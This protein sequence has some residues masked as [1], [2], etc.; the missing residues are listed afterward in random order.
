M[1]RFILFI[2][3][4]AFLSVV[5]SKVTHSCLAPEP[6]VRL[7]ILYLKAYCMY[8]RPY[9]AYEGQQGFTLY[10]AC[11]KELRL[12]SLMTHKNETD[13][14]VLKE[15]ITVRMRDHAGK[16]I[17]K[18]DRGCL[19][20]NTKDNSR[21]CQGI[22]L[23]PKHS[24]D[25]FNFGADVYVQVENTDLTIGLNRRDAAFRGY[26]S[27]KHPESHCEIPLRVPGLK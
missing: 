13:E 14:P 26:M 8:A 4:L 2:A 20:N 9:G 22:T 16:H 12:Y 11:D 1:K 23:P 15:G 19:I 17:E 5:A 6:Q 10:N 7:E 27:V 24:L 21:E 18:N 25:I 3:G